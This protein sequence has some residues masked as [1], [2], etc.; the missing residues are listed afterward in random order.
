M[1]EREADHALLGAQLIGRMFTYTR[2]YA[3]RRN[4]LFI[5]AD[6][7]VQV[8]A[9]FTNAAAGAGDMA[10]QPE[11]PAESEPS[12]AQGAGDLEPADFHPGRIGGR[13]PGHPVVCAAGDQ[14]RKFLVAAGPISTIVRGENIFSPERGTR[15]YAFLY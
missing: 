1:E 2:R 8:E 12:V 15:S 4:W 10:G 9:V 5:P 14:P 3:A 6:G 13:H 11:L 7:L